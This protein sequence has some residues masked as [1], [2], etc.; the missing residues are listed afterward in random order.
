M[1]AD[2]RKR[3]R[4]ACE[5]L[6]DI[7]CGHYRPTPLSGRCL[8]DPTVRYI[9]RRGMAKVVR[10]YHAPS[11]AGYSLRRTYIDTGYPWARSG[12]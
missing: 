3:F 4:R 6:R 9:L 2:K 8:R 7:N 12:R 5:Y 11:H 1:S 10:V